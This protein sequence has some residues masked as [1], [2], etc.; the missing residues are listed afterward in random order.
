MRARDT[1]AAAREVQLA[2]LRALGPARRVE[3]ALE[4]SDQARA[5]SLAGLLAR[6][7]ELSPEQARARLLRRILGAALFDAAWPGRTAR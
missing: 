1:A 6:E 7:P 2:A 4:M 5:V 3:L